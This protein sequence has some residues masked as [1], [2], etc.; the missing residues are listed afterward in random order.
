VAA[1]LGVLKAGAAYL[2]LDPGQPRARIELMLAD[3]KAGFVLTDQRLD[4]SSVRVLR[5]DRPADA[6]VPR[7]DRAAVGSPE[8]L[9]YVVF[10]SGSTGRPKPVAVPHRAVVNHAL[11]M[12][13]LFKLRASDRVLQFASAGFDVLAEE[14]F[15]T[16]LA[17]ARVVFGPS[18]AQPVQSVAEFEAALEAG[19]VTV[20]NLPSSFWA[21]WTKELLGARRQ[22]SASL[23]VVVIGSEHADGRLLERWRRHSGVPVANVYGV[24][25]AAVSS[26]ALMR[27]QSTALGKV[28]VG[29]PIANT[30]ACI[31]DAALRPVPSGVVGE[32]FLGG[33]GLAQGY[34]GRSELTA[35]RFLPAPY[36]PPGSRLY[37][38]GDL[39]RRLPSGLLEVV[40]RVDEQVKIR[41]YRI[42]LGD[43]IPPGR[44]SVRPAGGRQRPH[45]RARRA[46][47]GRLPGLRRRR[48]RGCRPAPVP[49]RAAAGEHGARTVR[50]PRAAAGDGQRQTGPERPAGAGRGAAGRQA[51]LPGA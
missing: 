39:A 41:G 5:M 35:E 13:D 30:Q 48:A 40:G 34:L 38:T 17:G 44:A 1:L 20:V 16:L 49:A 23:R 24:S 18:T 45:R 32:L 29:R 8:Q 36:G 7:G 3:A 25:E 21:Q 42:E 9:A 50:G 28:P 6:A 26:I 19:A 11:A 14:V 31:L 43:R 47:P 51:N 22:P 4:V 12:L 15:P 27:A 33:L 2:P 46:L 37:R 10:T